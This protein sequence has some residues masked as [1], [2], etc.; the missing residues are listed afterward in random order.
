MHIA[1]PP[2]SRQIQALEDE[3]GSTLIERGARPVRLTESGQ[4]FF[5]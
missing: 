1:Q 2:L 5:D 3:M 4:L